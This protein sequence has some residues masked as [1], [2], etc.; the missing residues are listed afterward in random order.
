MSQWIRAC[1]VD[2]IDVEDVAPLV[3][4]ERHLAV[5]HSEEGE[6]Y[7]TDGHC[8]HERAL[9]CEGLAMDGVIECPRHNG[10][11]DYRSGRALGAPVLVDLRT[12]PVSVRD[13]YVY[14]DID[15]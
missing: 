13:G 4:G 2:S 12:Y 10:Q 9:L 1:A 8:T 6:Y 11:F 14:V 7:A 5:Y 15:G 3:V